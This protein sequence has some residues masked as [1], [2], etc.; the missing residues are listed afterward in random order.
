MSADLPVAPGADD[1]WRIIGIGGDR[2]CPELE[3]Y[4]HCRSCPV[5]ARAA[6]G[7]F[8]RPA[9]DG[10]L[11]EW[12]RL[13]S[14]EK[15]VIN[16][17]SFSVLIFRLLGEWLAVRTRIL[18][19]VTH[20]RPVHRVPHRDDPTLLGLVSIRGQLQLCVSLH[21][22]LDVLSVEKA[23]NADEDREAARLIRPRL[24]VVESK[25]KRWAFPAEEVR[26][27]SRISREELRAVP[28]TLTKVSSFSQA[29]F[30][31]REHTVGLLD[32]Q[33]VLSALRSL[34]Q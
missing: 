34:G 21:R 20:T 5:Y 27:V 23:S 33:R 25:S 10:Y 24:V 7:F 17:D 9:P 29:V 19:E 14:R 16:S 6:R 3:T 31:W 18:A 4:I 1:C 12:T 15:A 2:T 11:A 30:P 28:S 8:D 26:G 32:D 13:L 22:L